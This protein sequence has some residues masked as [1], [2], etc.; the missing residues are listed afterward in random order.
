MY[1]NVS[2]YY[3]SSINS[4][5]DAAT[6]YE[7]IR[8]MVETGHANVLVISSKVSKSADTPI[9]VSVSASIVPYAV[10]TSSVQSI[11]HLAGPTLILDRYAAQDL[12]RFAL[13]A[14]HWMLSSVGV[15]N[16]NFTVPIL[17][18]RSFGNHFVQSHGDITHISVSISRAAS[19]VMNSVLNGIVELVY[20]QQHDAVKVHDTVLLG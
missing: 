14:R 3:N 2:G 19:N 4:N 9:R 11:E 15:Q 6:K 10:C 12:W 13:S 1:G 20:H 8:I 5:T 7:F 18:Y 17:N 16:G